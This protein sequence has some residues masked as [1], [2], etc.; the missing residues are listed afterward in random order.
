MEKENNMK[1]HIRK[2]SRKG[3]NYKKEPNENVRIFKIHSN[4]KNAFNRL[5]RR[6]ST[7]NE[8][9]KNLKMH[10]KK[11]LKLKYRKK[12]AFKK[13]NTRVSKSDGTISHG[14][15]YEV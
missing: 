5:S 13:Q 12:N 4:I 7:V 9:I 8:R 10:Q 2:F 1:D 3:E 11:L 14:L 15:I 6:L